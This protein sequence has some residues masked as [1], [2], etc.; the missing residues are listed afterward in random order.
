MNFINKKILI[1]I[2]YTITIC[3]GFKMLP[4]NKIPIITAYKNID[5]N[6]EIALDNPIMRSKLSLISSHGLTD[7]IIFNPVQV[8]PRYFNAACLCFYTSNDIKGILLFLFSIYH[9][10]RDM[11]GTGKQKIIQSL[12]L[13]T[14]FIY[15]PEQVINYLFF[16]HTPIHFCKFFYK[17]DRKWFPIILLFTNLLYFLPYK[18]NNINFIKTFSTFAIFGHIFSHT[19]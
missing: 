16:I 8:I 18:K 6:I 14:V 7:L 3:S 5:K 1:I 19:K 17:F 11:I 15:K 13:H 4:I 12:L 10:S 2:F 9:F